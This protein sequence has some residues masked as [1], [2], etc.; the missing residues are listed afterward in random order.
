MTGFEA[1]SQHKV[2]VVGRLY[3]DFTLRMARL[4]QGDEK[5]HSD[6]HHDSPGGNAVNAARFLAFLGVEVLL[7]A[8]VGRDDI[9]RIVMKRLHD[10]GVDVQPRWVEQTAISIVHPHD[11]KRAIALCGHEHY[12]KGSRFTE[13]DVSSVGAFHCDGHQYDAA[14]HHARECRKRGI[15]T[16][17][18][19]GGVREGI[20]ELLDHIDVAVMSEDFCRQKGLVDHRYEAA[21]EYL[22]S[23]GCTVGAVTCGERGVFYYEAD[24][25]IRHLKAI[26]VPRESVVNTNGAGDVF[27]G[28]YVYSYLIDPNG[29][30]EWHFLFASAAAA[31]FIQHFDV[32]GGFPSASQVRAILA[33]HNGA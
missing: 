30:W 25:P 29:S 31:Y 21:L 17:L 23:K 27:H 10:S 20:D 32:Q 15:L 24:G 18:D 14:I 16:S 9:G 8:A 1:H 6:E 4:P 26:H 12:E 5:L 19:G 28:A 3:W 2:L 33:S 22:R 11:G 7:H 13:L